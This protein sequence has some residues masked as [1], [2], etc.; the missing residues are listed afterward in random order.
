M[1]SLNLVPAAH[2]QVLLTPGSTVRLM[3]EGAESPFRGV[4]TSVAPAAWIV[5]LPDGQMRSVAPADVALAEVLVTRRNTLR[6]TLIGGGGGLVGGLL[7]VSTDNCDPRDGICDA[8]EEIFFDPLK[9]V[10]VVST[11]LVGAAMGALVGTLV[12]SDAWVPGFVSGG[13]GGGALRWTVPLT[14][15]WG[16]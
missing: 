2:G 7:I 13:A 11:T 12:T 4:L 6:G 8:V 1:A 15:G 3:L 10:M 9:P 5:A 16:R 14:L